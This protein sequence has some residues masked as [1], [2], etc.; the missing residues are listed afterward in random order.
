MLI[1]MHPLF[2][3]QNKQRKNQIITK[4]KV[5]RIKKKVFMNDINK[6]GK[7]YVKLHKKTFVLKGL[8]L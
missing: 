7:L 2:F 1:C 8:M 3:V 6:K 4:N 5:K